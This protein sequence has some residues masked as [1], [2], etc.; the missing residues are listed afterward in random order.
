[1]HQNTS[2]KRGLLIAVEGG[3][4]CGKSTQCRLLCTW[5]QQNTTH[6]CQYLKFPGK[7]HP[8]ASIQQ[9]AQHPLEKSST[10]ISATTGTS[11]MTTQ[12]ICSLPPTAGSSSTHHPFPATHREQIEEHLQKGTSIVLDRYVYSGAAYG[13]AKGLDLQWCKTP[14]RGLPQPDVV[15]FID[16]PVDQAAARAGYGDERYEDLAFQQS[17]RAQFE[18]LRDASWHMVGGEGTPSEVHERIAGVLQ[19]GDWLGRELGY[20]CW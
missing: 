10:T 7:P 12:S 16:L 20:I 6:P 19:R 4:R 3:D 5:L 1:M 13:A 15:L 11:L 8:P 9:T 2:P 18:L 14:D 17:V